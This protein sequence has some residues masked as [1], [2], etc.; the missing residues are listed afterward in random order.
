MIKSLGEIPGA[1]LPVVADSP[2]DRE[3][4]ISSDCDD[5]VVAKDE[6]VLIND[7]RLDS[8]VILSIPSSELE[9]EIRRIE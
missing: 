5:I 4:S 6:L 1:I 9:F 8:D 3:D 7:N 2:T